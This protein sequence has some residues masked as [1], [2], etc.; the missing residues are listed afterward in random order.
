MAY[1]TAARNAAA[2]GAP[3]CRILLSTPKITGRLYGNM[4]RESL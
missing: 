2:N 1:G 4:Q 3:H